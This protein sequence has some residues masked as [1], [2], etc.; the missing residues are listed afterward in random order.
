MKR[1]KN[2]R[3]MAT[4]GVFINPKKKKYVPLARRVM[5]LLLDSG[6]TVALKP[7]TAN[8]FRKPSYARTNFQHG[9]ELIFV[10]GG[11][12]TLI[13]AARFVAPA[14]TPLFGINTG[15]FGF[16]T[17]VSEKDAIS[18]VQHVLNGKYFLEKRMMLEVV[19]ER[20]GKPMKAF[21]C[22]NDM[23]ISHKSLSR[24]VYW[25]TTVQKEY[26]T[27]YPADGMIVSTPTGSTAYSLSAGG[28]VV[29]PE[30][31][32]LLLTPICPHTLYSRPLV[33]GGDSEIRIHAGDMAKNIVLTLDGQE[34]HTLKRDDEVV[35]RKAQ[36][37]TRLVQLN[38]K[39]FYNKLR[40][41]LFWG[42]REAPRTT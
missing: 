22:L 11:D 7:E 15:R 39:Q 32:V 3:T 38:K 29:H 23:V 6:H 33:L 42:E 37:L 36:C 35:A 14:A 21:Y 24:L 40:S 8:L 17:E 20:D 2:K 18:G 10:C 13:S 26:I 34:G 41:K 27:T 5:E 30:L 16:L 25:K 28:P 19:I 4:Y 12:G 9:V 1:S 31:N